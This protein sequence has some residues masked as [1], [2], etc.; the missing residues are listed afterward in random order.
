M[1]VPASLIARLSVP[2]TVSV[3]V[4]VFAPVTLTVTVPLVD[5]RLF[6]LAS[7]ACTVIDVWLLAVPAG[8]VAVVWLALAAPA[9]TLKA[10]DVPV[11]PLVAVIVNPVPVFVIVTAWAV[12]TP[13]LKDPLVTGVPV[14][15]PVEVSDAVL[16]NDVTVL[17]CASRAVIR[18]LN[19]VPAVCVGIAPPPWTS[20]KKLASAPGATTLEYGLPLI[21]LPPIVI[22][23]ASVPTA[24]GV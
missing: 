1:A 14:S 22:A 9:T 2:T 18:M 13:L 12:R 8:T 17:L 15:V 24:V 4:A 5:V 20:T 10:F 3:Y 11:L 21:A 7:F 16:L 23:I 19:A 6:P